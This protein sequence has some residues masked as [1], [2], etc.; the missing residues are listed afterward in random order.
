MTKDFS[1]IKDMAGEINPF[2]TGISS[3]AT[4]SMT[5]DMAKNISQQIKTGGGIG[6]GGVKSLFQGNFL[7]TLMGA[8]EGKE[9][10]SEMLTDKLGDLTALSTLYKLYNR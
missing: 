3:F 1:S 6:K 2:L 5:G 8:K 9:D 7:D 10:G 4:S